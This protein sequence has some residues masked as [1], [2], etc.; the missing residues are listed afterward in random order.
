MSVVCAACILRFG[1]LDRFVVLRCGSGGG[2]L[3]FGMIRDGGE[4]GVLRAFSRIILVVLMFLLMKSY[5]I[6]LCLVV[7]FSKTCMH[8]CYSVWRYNFLLRIE[9]V[10]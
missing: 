8:A 4:Q 7:S 1:G 9:A 10:H 3:L 6:V 5:K 2:G